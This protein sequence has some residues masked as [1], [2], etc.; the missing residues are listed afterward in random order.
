MKL[1]DSIALTADRGIW[2]VG[3]FAITFYSREHWP[4]ASQVVTILLICAFSLWYLWR[5]FVQPFMTG[6]K[7]GQAWR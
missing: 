2:S 3:C 5:F 4:L 1:P 7:G 6:M